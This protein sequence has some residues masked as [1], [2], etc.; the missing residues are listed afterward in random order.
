MHP[1]QVVFTI[2]FVGAMAIAAIIALWL[3]GAMDWK[4][5]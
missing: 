4:Q 2:V 3:V 5:S 1:A